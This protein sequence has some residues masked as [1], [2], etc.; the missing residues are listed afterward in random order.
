MNK[1]RCDM[2]FVTR[3][4]VTRHHG[5]ALGNLL[6]RNFVTY[7]VLIGATPPPHQGFGLVS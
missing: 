3:Q 5:E 2:R 7:Q 1:Q 4:P 6:S